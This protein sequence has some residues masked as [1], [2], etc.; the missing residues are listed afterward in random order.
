QTAQAI[1]STVFADHGFSDFAFDI[2]SE[3]KPLE[4]VVMYQESYYNFCAR[5]MEQEGLI[6]THRYEKDKHTLVIGDSNAMFRPIEGLASVPYADSAS[7]EYNGIDQLN[8][9]GHFGVGKI[10]YRDFNHQTPSSPLMMV[11]VEST[12]K[13]ARLATTE[14]FEHQ[15][16]Y[17]HAADGDRYALQAIE[18]EE[19]EGQR[20]TGQGYA[21][22]MTT[23]GSVSVTGHPVAADNQAYVILQVRHE[24]VNDYTAHAA[25]LPY[26]NSFVLLPQKVAYRARRV[27]P[28]PLI[29]G[30]QSAIVVGPKGEQIHTN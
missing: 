6:W 15:S 26:R 4:Y 10:V 29:Q 14:R 28:K 18:A 20:Y 11:E 22:R 8:Q 23:A 27:T 19:A 7:S 5:L 21:W 12:L 16:L 1:L 24:A 3:Q 25:K 30:T 17:D 2:H 13:Y 9:G